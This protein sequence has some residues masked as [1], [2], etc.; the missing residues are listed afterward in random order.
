MTLS[1]Y[2]SASLVS[3]V[4]CFAAVHV[5]ALELGDDAPQIVG[6]KTDDTLFALTRAERKPKVINFFWVKCLPCKKEIPLLAKKEKQYPQVE[7]IVVHAQMNAETDSNYDI[8]HIQFFINSLSGS[9]KTV[10][11]GSPL[12]KSYYDIKAFP[13]TVLLAS[14]NS[15]EGILSGFNDRTV[16]QLENW[17]KKQK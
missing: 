16:I 6:R 2:F 11:L 1:K 7:F 12:L 13:Y 9:P 17:L 5:Q 3:L 8:E 10:V 14:D 4:L 15:V